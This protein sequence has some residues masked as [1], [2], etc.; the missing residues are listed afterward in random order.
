MSEINQLLSPA[1]LVSCWQVGAITALK[2]AG[3]RPCAFDNIVKAAGVTDAIRPANM[4]KTIATLAVLTGIPLGV[5]A[6]V[7]DR[8]VNKAR[9]KEKELQDRISYY[10]N[11][12]RELESGLT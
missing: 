10:R 5:A 11:A 9:G 8:K 3:V 4:V 2:K 7:V 1:E 12:T 6:H